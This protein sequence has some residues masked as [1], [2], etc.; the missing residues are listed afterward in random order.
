MQAVYRFDLEG[1][2]SVDSFKGVPAGDL[3]F[4]CSHLA[5]E[6]GQ[7]GLRITLG[8]GLVAGVGGKSPPPRPSWST[9][10]ASPHQHGPTSWAL[11]PGR[12]LT[13]PQ[14]LTRMFWF[15]LDPGGHPSLLW[16][17]QNSPGG[18]K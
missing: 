8:G 11:T 5:E 2:G 1:Q 18:W 13:P 12:W 17:P 6:V 3:V 16:W 4:S 14:T 7:Q 9:V 10:P 15:D